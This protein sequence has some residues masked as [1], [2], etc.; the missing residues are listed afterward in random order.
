[1]TIPTEH[2]RRWNGYLLTWRLPMIVWQVLFFLV[3]LIFMVVLSFWLVKNY[4]MEPALVG[5]NWSKMMSRDY[6]WDA[7]WRT[8]ALAAGATVV[9]SLLAFPASFQ[10]CSSSGGRHCSPAPATHPSFLRPSP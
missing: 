2:S 8:L 7:Y 6:F 10:A 4:R 9:T 3:P 5:I 1:M